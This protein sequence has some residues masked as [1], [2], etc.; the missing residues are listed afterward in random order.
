MERRVLIVDDEPDMGALI[1]A[2]LRAVGIDTRVTTQP[3]EALT[4]VATEDFDT[5]LTDLQMPR[6][7]GLEL[8]ERIGAQRP[9]VPVIVVTGHGT[10]ESAIGAIRAGAYDFVQKPIK[11]ETLQLTVERALRHRALSTEVQRLREAT[12]PAPFDGIIGQSSAMRAVFGVAARVAPT[13]A[14]VLLTGES[15]TGKE[16]VARALH[17]RSRRAP[18]PF[19][20]VNLAAVPE[21]LVESELFGHARGAFT[22]AHAARTGLFLQAS[23]GTLFLDEIGEMPLS[24]QPKLLRALQERTIRPVGGDHEVPF[25]VRIVAATNRDLEA[26]VDEARFR[27]DLFYRINVVRIAL[28]PLRARGSDVLLLAQQAVARFAARMHK[29]VRGI[30][31][32]AA[33]KLLGYQWPGNVRELQN[34]LESAVAL[35][36]FAEL[37]VEDL[38]EKI[39]DY[40]S[41]HVLVA[42][43]GD[44]EELPTLDE[45]EKRYILRVMDSVHG[46]KALASRILGLDRK[47]LYRKLERY[48][49]AD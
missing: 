36:R 1:D 12:Q 33:E 41:S 42:G 16:L 9:D 38:P 40:H 47:T 45:V 43:S 4:L 11:V 15:G 27:E 17:Q 22:D 26:L 39:R 37:T 35:T 48:G 24:V 49:S 44:P 8:C 46:N 18:G 31:A 10:L 30:S 5:V 13:D 23:G 29:P 19:V 7:S 6:M 14:S 32:Q 2:G 20:A 34:A 25:D 28:P 3:S 21:P